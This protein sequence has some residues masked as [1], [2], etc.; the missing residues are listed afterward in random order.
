MQYYN[1]MT[2]AELF[3]AIAE[4]N[5]NDANRDQ[6]AK[7]AA[8]ADAIKES[9]EADKAFFDKFME[10]SIRDAKAND[11]FMKVKDTLLS[12]ALY[13]IYKESMSIPMSEKDKLVARHLVQNFVKEN[14]AQSLINNFRTKNLLLSEVAR[15]CTKHYNRIVEECG[16]CEDNGCMPTE[17][18]VPDS[19]V[20]DFMSELSDIDIE[21][22]TK[23]IKQRVSDSITQ[24]MDD[25]ALAKLEYEEI[26]NNAKQHIEDL[27]ANEGDDTNTEAKIEECTNLAN[28]R[29]QE[30][31][32][33]RSKNVFHHIVQSLAEAAIKDDK[34]KEVYIEGAKLNID[35]VVESAQLYLNLLEMVNTTEMI[36]IDEEYINN[37]LKSLKTA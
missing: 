13:R 33:A 6:Q 29:I 19:I 37:Y 18:V 11:F 4:A 27:K 31:E 32:L 17:F 9:A 10:A 30:M 22:A 3:K 35:K 12:E 25:N 28:R 24:F 16:T 36:K 2:N 26:M 15:V 1:N 20:D 5:V 7:A 23:L 21:D 14:G 8:M 34:L